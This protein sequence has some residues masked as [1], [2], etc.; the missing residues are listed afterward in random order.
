MTPKKPAKKTTKQPVMRTPAYAENSIEDCLSIL[1]AHPNYHRIEEII[2]SHPK[3]DSIWSPYFLTFAINRGLKGPRP[4]ERITKTERIKVADRIAK[5]TSELSTLFYKIHGSTEQ[6]RD[7]PFEFQARIDGFS[8]DAAID[9]REWLGDDNDLAKSLEED[10]G[11]A[12]HAMRSGIE[13]MLMQGMP[14][15]M[16]TLSQSAIWWKENGDS[17]LA[18]PNH[19]NANRLYFIRTMTQA[20]MRNFNTPMRALV[21]EI[22][23][24]YFDTS[25]LSEADLSNLAPVRN[26]TK[27]KID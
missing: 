19:K 6:E 13:H 16:D 27:R 22:T 15:L 7:W 10:D 23:S 5:L 20:C 18:M 11:A 8:L 9:F 14:E 24:V 4:H 3:F 25:D 2:R 17:P 26:R 12:F 21:L 1:R